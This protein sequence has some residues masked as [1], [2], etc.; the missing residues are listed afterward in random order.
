MPSPIAS[1]SPETPRAP[2]LPRSQSKGGWKLSSW[3]LRPPSRTMRSP[4]IHPPLKK[5]KGRCAGPLGCVVGVAAGYFMWMV[6]PSGS[7]VPFTRTCMPSYC[8]SSSG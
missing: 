2:S 5:Q 6:L 4:S 7:S 8:F 3:T 1:L